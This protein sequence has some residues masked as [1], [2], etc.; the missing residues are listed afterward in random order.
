MK[1][2]LIATILWK[3]KNQQDYPT[4]FLQLIKK[5]QHILVEAKFRKRGK[6]MLPGQAVTAKADEEEEGEEREMRGL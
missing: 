3:Q 2:E 4:G 5:I 1:L 6:E